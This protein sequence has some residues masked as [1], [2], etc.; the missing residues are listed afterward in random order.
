VIDLSALRL[1]PSRV[2]KFLQCPARWGFSELEGPQEEAGEGAKL[3]T[4][5]HLEHEL[6]YTQ[7]RPY[8]T[9]T[10]AGFIASHMAS[11]LP[12]V[13]PEFGAVEHEMRYEAEPGLS[14]VGRLDMLWPDLER[15][16]VIVP[17][18]KTTAHMK[19]AKL[20]RDALFGH[21]QAPFYVLLGMRKFAVSKA[22][23]RW[24][25]ATT[26][27]T[28][29]DRAGWR[30]PMLAV[31]AHDI[32]I[33]EAT[34]R[35]HLRMV[36][37][38]REMLAIAKAGTPARELPKNLTACDSYNRRCPYFARCQPE[39][40]QQMESNFLKSLNAAQSSAPAAGAPPA[41]EAPPAGAAPVTTPPAGGLFGASST[42]PATPPT[43]TPPVTAP[44]AGAPDVNPPEAGETGKGKGKGR[45]LAGD[46]GSPVLADEAT[47]AALA[48][49]I[50]DRLAL[51]LMG[52]VK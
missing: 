47:I 9:T 1:S 35:V 36:P 27:T 22:R 3:G 8:D 51:R 25:Y 17:D 16:Y 33:D 43:A 39:K 26:D 42:P 32:S 19:Y 49:A 31:S 12:P 41:P 24:V 23:T 29:G 45:K 13:L 6:Y 14:L 10:R 38:A 2:E 21:A 34:E 52:G 46:K 7:G 18:H 28:I 30:P 37:Q 50:V 40:H 15:G 5:V 44:D 48:D 4:A 20:E 11:K